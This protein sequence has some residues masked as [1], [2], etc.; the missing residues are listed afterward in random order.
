MRRVTQLDQRQR[1]S[2]DQRAVARDQRAVMS[3]FHVTPAIVLAVLDL[4]DLL[5]KVLADVAQ[6]QIA[7]RT[8]ER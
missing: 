5:P 2:G 3:A 6:V 8:V 1:Q 4:V 7:G